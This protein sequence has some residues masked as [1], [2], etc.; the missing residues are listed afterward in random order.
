MA[1]SF[2]LIYPGIVSCVVPSEAIDYILTFIRVLKV[3][4]FQ[5]GSR[6]QGLKNV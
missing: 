6:P 1:D 2:A 4:V 3:S 5:H